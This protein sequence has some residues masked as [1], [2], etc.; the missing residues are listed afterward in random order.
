MLSNKKYIIL[1]LIILVFFVV[2]FLLFGLDNIKKE[3]YSTAIVVG[4]D[5]VFI[6]EKQQW[7]DITGNYNILNWEKFNVYVNNEKVGNYYLWYDDKWY[8]F[9]K[10]KKPVNLEGSILG[11]SSN[12]NINVAEFTE[13]NV[14]DSIYIDKVL[15]DND[16]SKDQSFTTKYKIDFDFDNDGVREEFFLISNV[17]NLE[18][19]PEKVFSIVFMVKDN[20]IYPIYRDIKNNE[21][22]DGCKPYMN[23]FLDVDE[24]NTYEF[25]L[26]CGKYSVEKT[27]N[28]LYKFKDNKFKIL[29]SN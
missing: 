21:S 6:L 29:V 18:E 24:D 22:F 13:E 19:T 23:T 12:Y 1:I 14:D 3:N 28:M 25:I 17:F 5:S 7:I 9:D 27:I 10:K 2:M 11:I 8:A 16:F 4:E 15:E 26:S 20:E